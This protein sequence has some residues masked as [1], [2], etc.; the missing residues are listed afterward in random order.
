[1]DDLLLQLAKEGQSAKLQSLKKAAQDA[2]GENFFFLRTI[3]L[4]SYDAYL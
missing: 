1:M 3:I 4:F 2:C